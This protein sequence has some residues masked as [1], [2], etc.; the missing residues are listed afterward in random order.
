MLL[1]QG[2]RVPPNVRFE[3][4]DAK[5]EWTFS[6]PFDFI[7]VRALVGTLDDWPAFLEQC[8]R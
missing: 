7:H 2:A 4:D 5:K 1:T 3:I 8:Y 6:K